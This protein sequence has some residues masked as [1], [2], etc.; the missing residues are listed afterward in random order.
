MKRRIWPLVAVGLVACIH[1]TIFGADLVRWGI[2]DPEVCRLRDHVFLQ[3]KSSKNLWLVAILIFAYIVGFRALVARIGNRRLK[4]SAGSFV[5]VASSL[6]HVCFWG[7]IVTT[8][9]WL[10]L[11]YRTAVDTSESLVFIFGIALSEGYVFLKCFTSR[12]GGRHRVCHAVCGSFALL[13]SI[14]SIFEY[15]FVRDFFYRDQI[16]WHG[17]WINPNTCGLLLGVGLVLGVGL[18]LNCWRSNTAND[19][20]ASLFWAIVCLSLL[21]GLLATYSRGAI[22]S[23]T[24]ALIF[25]GRNW[26]RVKKSPLSLDDATADGE[27]DDWK[28]WR[29]W[30]NWGEVLLAGIKSNR[31]MLTLTALSLAVLIFWNFRH[32]EFTP[33]RR[34]L[35]VGNIND[36]SWRNRVTTY[37][38]A[39]RIIASDWGMGCGW[40]NTTALYDDLYRPSKTPAAAA[41]ALN[42]HLVL[43]MKLGIPA[44]LCFLGLCFFRIVGSLQRAPPVVFGLGREDEEPNLVDVDWLEIVCRAGALVLLI[45]FWFDG[46][47]FNVCRGFPF[48]DSARRRL[49]S[50]LLHTC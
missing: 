40:V 50:G 41:I 47:L 28:W 35:S 25:L 34:V 22:L 45:G 48:L 26:C 18:F 9:I 19:K 6:K 33:L 37:E 4:L 23:T 30:G 13:V 39:A 42:D 17:I 44:G 3:L 24:V 46:G 29:R 43:T 38:G 36:F 8:A 14:G 5:P 16:R 10:I 20:C 31:A 49:H 7:L 15:T 32:T 11:S 21:N 1:A 2:D 27:A 12:W